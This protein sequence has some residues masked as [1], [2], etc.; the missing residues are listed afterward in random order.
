MKT[1]TEKSIAKPAMI[2][3]LG[4]LPLPAGLTMSGALVITLNN[5]VR[6]VNPPKISITDKP[7]HQAT[8]SNGG[9]A[10]F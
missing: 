8:L 2:A 1:L 6:A 3:S 4:W 5:Q 7:K 10:S 9:C